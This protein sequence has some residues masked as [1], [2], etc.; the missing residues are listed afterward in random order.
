M[1]NTTEN[2]FNSVDS[3]QINVNA[4]YLENRT[5]VAEFDIIIDNNKLTKVVDI[6]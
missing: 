2:I 5:V 6:L 4:L 1:L 3:I